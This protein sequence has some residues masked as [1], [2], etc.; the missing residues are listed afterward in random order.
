MPS[1]AFAPG[2]PV[3]AGQVPLCVPYLEGREAKYVKECFD[4]NFISSVGPFVERFERD[5]GAFLG[6]VNAV[7]TVNGTAALHLSLL[8]V[9]V[10]HGDEVLAPSL[11]FI[12][13]ANAIRYCGAIPVFID[14]DLRTW[15]MDAGETEKFLASC[16]KRDGKLFNRATKRRIAAILVVHVLGHPVDMDAFIALGRKYGIPVVEDATESLGAE[17]KG[18]RTGTLGEIGSLSFNGN[19]LL[20]T[21]GGGMVVTPSEPLSRKAKYL[22]TQAKDDPLEYVHCEVGYN[23][24]LT[25]V[26]AA[27]GCAQL[28][29]IDSHI[30][31]KRKTAAFYRSLFDSMSGFEF[32]PHA[33]WAAPVFWL[34][35]VLVD[36]SVTGFSSRTLLAH[37]AAEGIQSRPLWQPLHVSKAFRGVSEP[38]RCPNA[39]RLCRDALSLPSSVGILDSELER[40]ADTILAFAAR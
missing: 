33:E 32:M 10:G 24:R 37:L 23:Y 7:A 13:P 21:G 29:R 30:A 4:T 3:A 39:E 40:V 22:S 15:Q 11:T 8:V 38:R 36:E 5:M 1:E 14:A 2:A 27:I 25:N 20:T 6:G 18:R 34:S 28:E 16:E 26:A 19:K 31:S 35:T 9:G 12:A 17:Y